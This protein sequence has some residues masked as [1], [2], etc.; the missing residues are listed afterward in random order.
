MQPLPKNAESVPIR[1][2]QALAASALTTSIKFG[3]MVAEHQST[4]SCR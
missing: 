1:M 2:V 3:A 4:F